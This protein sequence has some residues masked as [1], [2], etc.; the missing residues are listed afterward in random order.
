MC[1]LPVPTT[2]VEKYGLNLEELMA[3]LEAV[4]G[5]KKNI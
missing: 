3:D 1:L 2:I 4:A 5:F